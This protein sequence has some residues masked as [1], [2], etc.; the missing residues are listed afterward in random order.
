MKA[1][2][3]SARGRPPKP[4]GG[5]EMAA[6][7]EAM[8]TVMAKD[9]SLEPSV[10]EIVAEAGL[11]PKAFYRHFTTK[12]DL[13]VLALN[14]GSRLLAHYLQR[15][16]ARVSSSPEKIGEWIRGVAGQ[17][18]TPRAIRRTSPWSL[19]MGRLERD[20]PAELARNQSLIIDPLE[21]LIRGEVAAGRST[22]SDS[23]TD[24][25]VVFAAATD[26]LRRSLLARS[27]AETYE[28]EHLLEFTLRGLGLVA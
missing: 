21:E 8:W 24:A 27:A 16:M 23:K 5:A 25:R 3:G 7:V 2:S 4:Q 13:L 20:F 17:A 19:S 12:D 22:S 18:A 1:G 14:E 6:L 15:R 26:I 11:A 28:V 10:R 9:G